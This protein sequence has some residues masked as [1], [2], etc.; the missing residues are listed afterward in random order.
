MI[1]ET[2]PVGNLEA[3][4]Y[5]IGCEE[6]K[7]AAVIDPGGEAGRILGHINKLGLEVTAILLTHG[8]VDHIG[9]VGELKKTTAAPVLIHTKDGEML[10]NPTSNLSA[11]LGGP[12]QLDQADRLLEEGDTISVGNLTLTVIHTPGHTPGGICFS[13]SDQLFTGDTLFAG[14]IGRSDFPGGNQNTLIEGI[15][16]KLLVLDEATKVYPGHGPTTTIG[17]EKRQNPYL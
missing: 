14:S 6:T 11:W 10:T 13:V 2:L 12:V 17:Q 15:R 16:S 5:I 8:H 9:G 7:K 1:I 4:C 3:N